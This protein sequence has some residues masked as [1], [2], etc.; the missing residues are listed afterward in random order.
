M[1]QHTL[2]TILQECPGCNNKIPANVVTCPHCR[3]WL[4]GVGEKTRPTDK[5]TPTTEEPAFADKGDRFGISESEEGLWSGVSRQSTTAQVFGI[6]RAAFMTWRHL[7]S[8]LVML[9]VIAQLGSIPLFLLF[10]KANIEP[11]QFD[12]YTP[13]MV[14]ALGLALIVGAPLFLGSWATALRVIDAIYR[15]KKIT[16]SLMTVFLSSLSHFGRLLASFALVGVLM[17]VAISPALLASYWIKN[18]GSQ[19]L[20]AVFSLVGIVGLV[21][22]NVLLAVVLPAVVLEGMGP[23]SALRRSITLV[24]GRF[25]TVLG[26][27]VSY[28]LCAIIVQSFALMFMFN[29]VLGEIASTAASI[30]FVTPL[31][32]VLDYSLFRFLAKSSPK[33]SPSH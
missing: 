19:S 12:K 26:V 27:K 22:V 30:V 32:W 2:G 17:V 16:S 10:S 14:A 31:A 21:Y 11:S 13:S 9:A 18:G 4:R 15:R 1:R 25:M 20:G 28:W 24:R 6:L 7:L 33:Q 8:F 23:I 3:Y 5:E 29:Q